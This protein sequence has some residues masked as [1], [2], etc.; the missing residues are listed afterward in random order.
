MLFTSL[1]IRHL[2][3][4]FIFVIICMLS[5][6][7]LFFFF[8]MIRRPPRSTLFP[9]TTLFRSRHPAA[10]VPRLP[11]RVP[12]RSQAQRQSSTAAVTRHGAERDAAAHQLRRRHQFPA[13]AVD[14][15]EDTLPTDAQGS[16]K[17]GR[18]TCP[19]CRPVRPAALRDHRGEAALRRGP[20]GGMSLFRLVRCGAGLRDPRL[21]RLAC[22]TGGHT[23]RLRTPAEFSFGR[24]VTSLQAAERSRRHARP[25]IP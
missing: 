3:I 2:C 14:R 15:P 8:L 18:T 24:S 11:V 17:D 1:L 12:A 22:R 10:R 5:P 13:A 6:F 23:R 9:Y 4:Y 25:W 7:L 19:H 16:R 21:H 20:V